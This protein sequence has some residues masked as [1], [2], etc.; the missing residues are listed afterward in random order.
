MNGRYT[1]SLE[2]ERHESEEI[3][4]VSATR[5]DARLQDLPT[6]FQVLS[7]EEIEEK[8]TMTCGDITMLLNEMGAPRAND[9]TR[10]RCGECLHIQGIKGRYTRFLSGGLP[11]RHRMTNA[12]AKGSSRFSDEHCPDVHVARRTDLQTTPYVSAS[13]QGIVSVPLGTIS[14]GRN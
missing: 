14:E 6:R 3:T 2:P 10:S 7:R 9:I 8:M 12:A 11:S 4:T 5:T 13:R 1:L